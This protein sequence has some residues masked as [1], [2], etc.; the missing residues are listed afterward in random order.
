MYFTSSTLWLCI[1][2]HL[3]EMLLEFHSGECCLSCPASASASYNSPELLQRRNPPSQRSSTSGSI[4]RCLR[5]SSPPPIAN[6]A[7]ASSPA[8]PITLRSTWLRQRGCTLVASLFY[9]T[10]Y[11]YCPLS[12]HICSFS[13]SLKE[14]NVGILIFTCP[15]FQIPIHEAQD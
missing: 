10:C 8:N 12:T 13:V 14:K 1:L 2:R 6:S 15:P 5:S 4:S 3:L 7:G 9:S 11:I